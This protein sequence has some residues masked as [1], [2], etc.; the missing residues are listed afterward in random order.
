[1]KRSGLALL[2]VLVP[3]L[4]AAASEG[5]G[6]LGDLVW[7]VS[8]LV[9]LIVALVYFG[10]RPIRDFLSARQDRIRDDLDAAASALAQ[11]EARHSEWQRKLTQLDTEM[12]RIREQARERAEAER[13]HILADASAAAERI[14]RDARSAAD[15]E[16][17][18]ARE[19]LRREAAE[20]ALELAAET[21]RARVNDSDRSR[22]VD[23]FI[24]T[25][26][27]S[28]RGAAPGQ[29]SRQEGR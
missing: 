26:E 25:I 6:G 1:M 9:I 14:R 13:K 23:D 4:P 12:A 18:R 29:G 11:A 15:Q 22:L 8:N 20:L 28:D 21:L 24:E 7:P 10:R 19:E 16:L 3:V 27:R 2:L 5:G 17:R